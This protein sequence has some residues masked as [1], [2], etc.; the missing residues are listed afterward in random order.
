MGGA[1]H[2]AGRHES[3]VIIKVNSQ[4][5]TDSLIQPGT[6][7][8]LTVVHTLKAPKLEIFVAKFFTQSKPI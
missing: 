2:R 8:A 1:S 6:H 7:V 4:Q 5:V 3:G